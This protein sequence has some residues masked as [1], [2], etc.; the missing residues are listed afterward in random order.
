[1]LSRGIGTYL[2]LIEVLFSHFFVLPPLAT[3]M[4]PSFAQLMPHWP[5]ACSGYWTGSAVVGRAVLFALQD[6][7]CIRRPSLTSGTCGGNM[8]AI[9]WFCQ[10]P[11]CQY[12]LVG[13]DVKSHQSGIPVLMDLIVLGNEAQDRACAAARL[14]SEGPFGFLCYHQAMVTS[15]TRSAIRGVLRQ[16]AWN[17]GSARFR[18]KSLLCKAASSRMF[19]T[20]PSTHVQDLVLRPHFAASP[21]A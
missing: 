20:C 13:V 10:I 12:G 11:F 16:Q 14:P 19:S 7:E 21:P 3:W 18:A 5:V 9:V 8:R 2:S 6:G 4:P 15:P 1:M 17:G